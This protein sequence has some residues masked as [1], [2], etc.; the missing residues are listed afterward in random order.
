MAHAILRQIYVG[1]KARGHDFFYLI[2]CLKEEKTNKKMKGKK[3]KNEWKSC[4]YLVNMHVSC[5]QEVKM[6]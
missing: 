1:L 4:S 3:T 5:F 2:D 6:I